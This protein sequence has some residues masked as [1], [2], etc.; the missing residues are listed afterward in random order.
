MYWFCRTLKLSKIASAV[1]GLAYI[2]S[3]N[4][5]YWGLIPGFSNVFVFIPLFFG[6]LLKISENK[7]IFWLWGGLIVAYGLTAPNTQVVFFTFIVGFFWALFLTYF[8][9]VNN[10]NGVVAKFRP[11]FGYMGFIAGGAVLASFWLLPTIN[12]MQLST[13][14][15]S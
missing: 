15:S 12:Y 3:Q 11:I 10:E 7:K 13:R 14:G 4:S 8:H 1:G 5:M 6:A 2:F 9:N